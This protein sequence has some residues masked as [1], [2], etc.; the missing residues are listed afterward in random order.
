MAPYDLHENQLAQPH[1]DGLPA[2][3]RRP[4]LGEGQ[5][6]E[7]VEQIILPG[8]GPRDPPEPRKGCEH[9]IERPDV[10]AEKPADE[11]GPIRS[12]TAFVHHERQSAGR[13]SYRESRRA[14]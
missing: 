3:S 1:A 13:E 10:A 7:A 2:R 5:V 8:V 12:A 9:G 4:R 11:L 6:D 14:S